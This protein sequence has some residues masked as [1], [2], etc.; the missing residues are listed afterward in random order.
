M[1]ATPAPG[2]GEI[3]LPLAANGFYI[4]IPPS[5]VKT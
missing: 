3:L 4:T 1:V 2:A 5:T